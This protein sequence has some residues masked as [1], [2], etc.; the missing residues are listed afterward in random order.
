M[1]V[2]SWFTLGTETISAATTTPQRRSYS[3][4]VPD[5]RYEVR[6]TRND[7]KDTNSRAGHELDWAGLRAYLTSSDNF[8]DVTLVAMKMRATNNLSNQARARST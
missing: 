5:G 8:G 1:A 7:S 4:G 3:Y 2:G 6:L